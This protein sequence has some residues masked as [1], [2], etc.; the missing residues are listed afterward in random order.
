MSRWY[1][2]RG[3]WWRWPWRHCQRGDAGHCSSAQRDA[4]SH[5]WRHHW[6]GS[7]SRLHLLHPA[8]T[9]DG[10]LALFDSAGIS[11]VHGWLIDP[12]SP[13]YPA[14]SRVKDYD[15]AMNLIVEADV[16]TRGLFVGHGAQD[17]GDRAGSSRAGQ[18]IQV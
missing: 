14:F 16:L 2:W 6:Y 1:V 9:T 3:L 4:H 5:N 15:S 17:D 18:V 11:L 10:E 12:E 13:E 7:Q 8:A